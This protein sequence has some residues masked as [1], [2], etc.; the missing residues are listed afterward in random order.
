M[1]SSTTLE[2][3]QSSGLRKTVICI[4]TPLFLNDRK[5]A[6]WKTYMQMEMSQQEVEIQNKKIDQLERI[7]LLL[8]CIIVLMSLNF[9]LIFIV[10]ILLK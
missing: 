7:I 4:T 9:V 8:N 10:S 1:I 5:P 2:L 3:N 6:G